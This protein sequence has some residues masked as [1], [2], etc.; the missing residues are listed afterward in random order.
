MEAIP[1]KEYGLL[2]AFFILFDPF[3][4]YGRFNGVTDRSK[5]FASNGAVGTIC[6]TIKSAAAGP[7]DRK[8]IRRL[9]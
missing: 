5:R 9:Q 4:R 2:S 8:S 1:A 7:R 6:D 3:G